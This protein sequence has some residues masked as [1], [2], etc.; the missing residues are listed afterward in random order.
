MRVSVHIVY[1]LACRRLSRNTRRLDAP[2]PLWNPAFTSKVDH[3]VG[4]EEEEGLE[5]VLEEADLQG[6]VV[7]MK[8]HAITTEMNAGRGAGEEAERTAEGV[9]VATAIVSTL[10]LKM[11]KTFQLW[12]LLVL[13]E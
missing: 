7:T 11:T 5:G 9:G 12:A 1:W 6:S 10:M 8:S 3:L 13:E 4:G 2:R